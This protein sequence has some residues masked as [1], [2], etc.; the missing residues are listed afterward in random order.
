MKQD[1]HRFQIRYYR[2]WL[3]VSREE[4][5]VRIILD[6]NGHK[7]YLEPSEADQLAILLVEESSNARRRT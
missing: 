5:N 4:K 2:N 3:G 6:V 7:V 1:P